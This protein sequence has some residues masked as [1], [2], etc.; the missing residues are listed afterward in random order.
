MG[1]LGGNDSGHLNHLYEDYNLTFGELR[2]VLESIIQNKITLYEKVDG[3]NLSL[4]HDPRGHASYAA[5]NKTDIKKSGVDRK[6]LEKRYATKTL[7]KEAFTDALSAFNLSVSDLVYYN[8]FQIFDKDQGGIP[9]VNLEVMSTDNPN[10]ITYNRNYLVMHGVTR[11]Q[12]GTSLGTA[13]PETFDK[14]VKA[15][16]GAVVKSPFTDK[17]WTIKGPTPISLAKTANKEKMN[18]ALFLLKDFMVKNHL[19]DED[20][21]SV[22]LENQI[23]L[24]YLK[25]YTLPS[26]IENEFLNRM[27]DVPRT[28]PT[29]SI[30]KTLNPAVRSALSDI[31]RSRSSIVRKI[32]MP[33]EMIINKFGIGLLE[34]SH[35]I[36]VDNGEDQ[37]KALRTKVATAVE[38]V[39]KENESEKTLNTLAMNYEKLSND[40]FTI[41]S[42]V[43]GVVFTL[44]NKRM[45]YKITGAFAPVNQILGMV[46]PAFSKSRGKEK[47]LPV[48]LYVG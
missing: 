14:V 26:E 32:I 42:T 2:S 43:E 12:E 29:P 28:R 24:D 17:F 1:G 8:R 9:F 44:P 7:V 4:T 41:T 22:Y 15:M 16:S 20:T 5:R 13:C 6:Q 3:Q 45:S 38:K 21:I 37:V 11:Y 10:V 27:L 48:P 40:V 36:F 33:L 39:R 30:V 35:S 19:E 31:A 46:N 34:N 47:P 18:E 25:Q 23:T